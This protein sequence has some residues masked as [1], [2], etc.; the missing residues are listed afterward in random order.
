M[1][2]AFDTAKEEIRKALV[3]EY[4]KQNPGVQEQEVIM[5]CKDGKLIFSDVATILAEMKIKKEFS[6][7]LEGAR[8][9]FSNLTVHENQRWK[10]CC[11]S[12]SYSQLMLD[13]LVSSPFNYFDPY[14]WKCEREYL[15]K[16]QRYSAKAT[17]KLTEY[18]EEITDLKERDGTI[19][20]PE[21]RSLVV[22][23]LN[24]VILQLKSL[25]L[26]YKKE[27]ELGDI[28]ADCASNYVRVTFEEVQTKTVAF[29]IDM[30][31]VNQFY[32]LLKGSPNATVGL[33]GVVELTA[34]VLNRTK[35]ALNQ[36]VDEMKT[37]IEKRREQFEEIWAMI[38]S[39]Q[40]VVVQ[41]KTL[42]QQIAD[43][44]SSGREPEKEE[45]SVQRMIRYQSSS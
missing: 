25:H 7:S 17:V 14:G 5:A 27:V 15:E 12:V 42:H 13:C 38:S 34:S 8:N 4:L 22:D 11:N 6:Q 2:D 33:E 18:K 39:M 24:W 31:Q 41:M 26:I 16:Q 1:S 35:I 45:K 21:G 40:H 23:Y 36:A 28:F 30:D 19:R 37:R 32:G 9:L 10:E 29:K 44:V 3:S 43:S 20:T